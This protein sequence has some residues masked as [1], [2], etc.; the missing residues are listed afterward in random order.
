MPLKYIFLEFA[1][2]QARASVEAQGDRV[3]EGAPEAC[4]GGEVFQSPGERDTPTPSHAGRR[5]VLKALSITLSEAGTILLG[6]GWEV[7]AASISPV[8]DE[9][10]KPEKE[11][12]SSPEPHRRSACGLCR[13][14]QPR[15]KPQRSQ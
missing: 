15:E 12:L 6:R 4:G 8:Q 11:K 14:Y 10:K 2:S 1:G 3:G 7:G 13:K 5:E 9:G